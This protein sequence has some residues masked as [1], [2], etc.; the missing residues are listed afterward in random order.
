[1]L[2]AT[3]ATPAT[4]QAPDQQGVLGVRES[5]GGT[6]PAT[7]PTG[8]SEVLGV[9]AQGGTDPASATAPAGATAPVTG[10]AASPAGSLPFT[11][12]DAMLVL[13]LGCVTLL[14]GVAL[15][16]VSSRRS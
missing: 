12:T 5:G 14:G 16:R 11:G 10:N 15:Q 4:E 8:A 13:L 9:N 1:V 3:A 2:P 6:A 7:A